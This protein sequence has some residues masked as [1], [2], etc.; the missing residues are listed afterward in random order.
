MFLWNTTNDGKA[1]FKMKYVS[2]LCGSGEVRL[3]SVCPLY[4]TSSRANTSGILVGIFNL[5]KECWCIF[6]KMTKR[7]GELRV[8]QENKTGVIDKAAAILNKKWVNCAWFN[9]SFIL[10]SSV[11]TSFLV[12]KL[13]D[14]R[15]VS[16]LSDHS[17]RLAILVWT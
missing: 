8:Q 1:S 2:K 4:Y 7:I 5:S 6:S 11:A 10:I 13:T 9:F 3:L 17:I 14:S 16:S 12:A 15:V